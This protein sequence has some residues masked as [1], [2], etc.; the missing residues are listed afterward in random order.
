MRRLLIIGSLF[1]GGVSFAVSPVIT[2]SAPVVKQGTTYQFT[3]T[4]SEAGTWSCSATNSTG[5]VTACSGS[6][7][8]ASG[9]YTAP[10]S[11]TAQH[12]YA[13]MQIGPN[14]SIW[15]VRIDSLPVNAL[16]TIWTNT[17]NVGG[18]P[19][20]N[21]DFPINYV[22][23]SNTALLNFHYTAPENG[24]FEVPV[25]PTGKAENGFFNGYQQ[26]DSNDHHV[27]MVDT[28]T[29]IFSEIYQLGPNCVTSAASVSGNIATLTCTTNPQFYGFVAGGTYVVGGF[30][31]ADTYFNQASTTALTVTSSQITFALNHANASASTNG[32]VGKWIGYDTSGLMNAAS[33]LTYSSMTYVLPTDGSTDAAG[34]PLQPLILGLQEFERAATTPGGSINHA[35]RN[36]FGIGFEASYSTWPATAFAVDGATVPF[37]ACMRLKRTTDISSFSSDA[38]IL[39]NAMKNYCVFNAD[40]GNNYP[41]NAEMTRWPKRYYDAMKELDSASLAG[42]MEFVKTSTAMVSA[43]SSLTKYNREIVTFTRTS[44]VATASVDIAL[45][46]PAVN[47]AKDQINIMAGTPATQLPVLNNYGG[48]SCAMSPSTGTLTS[49]CLYTPPANLVIATTTIVT[50]TSLVNSSATAIMTLTVFP[51]TGIFVIPSQTADYHDTLGNTWVSR[52]GTWSPDTQGC[53]ACDNSASFS[54]TDKTLYSCFISGGYDNGGDQHMDFYL[55]SATYVVTYN[56]GTQQAATGQFL[57][58]AIGSNEISSN[59]DP[60]ASAGGQ[61]K[62]YTSSTTV[63]VNGLLQVGIF[64]MNSQGGPVSSLSIVSTTTVATS[65]NYVPITGIGNIF[66]KGT[67][68]L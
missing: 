10:S 38:Q 51:S 62:N 4:A 37:G 66:G 48:Y 56:Y 11:V 19:H 45:M 60:A 13:G 3:E 44:D 68:H 47:F 8:S 63:V 12:V 43:T 20:W 55:P 25:F 42:S 5:G 6:I 57:K 22:N 15:N 46:G 24:T 32:A 18:T 54:G 7:N 9:L 41:M 59:L 58:F 1:I 29:S 50:A 2:Q 64:G 31:G 16:N 34:L 26:R 14:N 21:T 52:Q 35:F 30:T 17:V 36:T 33:I 65:S 39:L 53:C 40:G 27:V 28:T 67:I 49:G 23:S 61:F